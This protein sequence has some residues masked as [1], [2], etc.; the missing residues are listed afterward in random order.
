[1]SDIAVSGVLNLGAFIV[2]C[3]VV[4]VVGVA[5]ALFPL[6]L[7]ISVAESLMVP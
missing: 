3:T 4:V 5:L 2:G 1:M 6:P 7:L